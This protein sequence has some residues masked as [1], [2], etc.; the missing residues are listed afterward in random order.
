M[1]EITPHVCFMYEP[2]SKSS[3]GEVSRLVAAQLRERFTS[4]RT[5]KLW[6]LRSWAM[7]IRRGEHSYPAVLTPD[8]LAWPQH[9]ANAR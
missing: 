5:L 3:D 2:P 9:P 1:D 6:F 4:V 8:E 7:M